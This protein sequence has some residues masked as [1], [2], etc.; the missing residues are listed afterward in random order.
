MT[1]N[2][3]GTG[4]SE[5]LNLERFVGL[6]NQLDALG[7]QPRVSPHW[8]VQFASRLVQTTS[9]HQQIVLSTWSPR[10]RLGK[11]YGGPSGGHGGDSAGV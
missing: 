8:V 11:G 3:A 6:V 7:Y 10:S 9:I 5:L 1:D 4:P 2:G